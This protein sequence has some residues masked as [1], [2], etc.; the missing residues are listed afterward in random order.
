[1]SKTKMAAQK[2]LQAGTFLWASTAHM[3]TEEDSTLSEAANS[4]RADLWGGLVYERLSRGY[5][6]CLD[7]VPGDNS[8]PMSE[9]ADKV[10]QVA[11]K[12]GCTHV[13]F[14]PDAPI[15]DGAA[16]NEW[17]THRSNKSHEDQVPAGVPGKL[18]R[19]DNGF[20]II[21]T[22][23]TVPGTCG[24][25][26]AIR[27]ESGDLEI[28]GN[29]DTD[30]DWNEQRHARNGRGEILF[31]DQAYNIVPESMVIVAPDPSLDS[32]GC[33]DDLNF[34]EDGDIDDGL[35]RAFGDDDDDDNDD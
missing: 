14:D 9:G 15:V 31:V 26:S 34:D 27:D 28:E 20:S 6:V 30:M 4:G 24:I 12:A 21:G 13:R 19:A 11:R 17:E 2:E 35:H 18:V 1:M 3:T 10:V 16:V 8:F 23:D 22:L 29:G 7:S 5:L 25:L 32:E 33:E